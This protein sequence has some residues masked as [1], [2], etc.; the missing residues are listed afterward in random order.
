MKESNDKD[1]KQMKI[2]LAKQVVILFYLS[3]WL[4]LNALHMSPD[5]W[6]RPLVK[7]GRYSK[8]GEHKEAHWDD[9][10]EAE[11]EEGE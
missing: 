4:S 5:I 8:V 9:I 7:D 3:S 11:K 2:H 6:L 1:E 10:G